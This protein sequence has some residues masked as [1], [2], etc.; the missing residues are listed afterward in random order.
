MPFTGFMNIFFHTSADTVGITKNGAITRTRTMPRP[1]N[2]RFNNNASAMPPITV[3]TSTP[4]TRISVLLSAARN[5]G[6]VR[7]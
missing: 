3:I 7:K 4:T 2:G 1:Q 5:A 6:L